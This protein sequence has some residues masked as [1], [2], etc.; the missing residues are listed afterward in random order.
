VFIAGSVISVLEFFSVMSKGI[1]KLTLCDI[2]LE[3]NSL[4][5]AVILPTTLCH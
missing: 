2:K 1:D 4:A 3:I 5:C